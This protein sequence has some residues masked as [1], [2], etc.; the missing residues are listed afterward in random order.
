MQTTWHRA[1]WALRDLDDRENTISVFLNYDLGRWCFGPRYEHDEM[2]LDFNL[3]VGP[4]SLWIIYWRPN[5]AS[6]GLPTPGS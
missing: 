1:Q 4:L 3:D 2:W 6:H 5:I